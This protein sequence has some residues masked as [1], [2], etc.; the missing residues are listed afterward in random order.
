M[1]NINKQFSINNPLNEAH[2]GGYYRY[3]KPEE[4]NVSYIPHKSGL[5]RIEIDAGIEQV[6][7]F[8]T[9]IHTLGMAREEDQVE[10]VLS[11]CNGGSVDAGVAFIHAIRKCAA[12]IHFVATGG[13]HSMASQILLEAESFE[14]GEG[15]NSLIHSGCDGA[16]GTIPEYRAKSKFDEVFRI[17]QFKE[18]YKHFLSEKEID[19]VLSGQ[20]LWLD[21]DAWCTRFEARNAGF[22]AEEEI[23]KVEEALKKKEKINIKTLKTTNK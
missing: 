11:C 16:Y 8:S 7:Q 9:A 3:A 15:F 4:F 6:S 22:L 21:S 14:L 18:T 20:D 23:N 19:D 12:P 10:I 1:K 17:A 2:N 5:Y 13:N